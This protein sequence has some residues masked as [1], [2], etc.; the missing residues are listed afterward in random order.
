MSAA[1]VEW[2]VHCRR[3]ESFAP[4]LKPPRLRA[5]AGERMLEGLTINRTGVPADNVLAKLNR[6]VSRPPQKDA[7]VGSGER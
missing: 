3:Q 6:P 5:P 4:R 1:Q 7:R 2:R